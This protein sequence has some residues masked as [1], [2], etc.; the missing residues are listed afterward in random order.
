RPLALAVMGR[1]LCLGHGG[2]AAL[3]PAILPGAS[4]AAGPAGIA[5]T[6]APSAAGVGRALAADP[7]DT[8]RSG[9][10][11]GSAWRMARHGDGPGFPGR[12]SDR[13]TTGEA[14]RHAV[15]V[16]LPA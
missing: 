8:L 14:R 3:F 9:V 7:C 5:W 12:V 2:R 6:C 15:R 10:S 16:G 1:D 4:A 11:P 13:E